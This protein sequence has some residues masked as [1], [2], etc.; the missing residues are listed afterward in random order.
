[1]KYGR[2]FE[3]L[4]I[5]KTKTKLRPINGLIWQYAN[6]PFGTPPLTKGIER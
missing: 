6:I 5:L 4:N 3:D 2:K 1:M